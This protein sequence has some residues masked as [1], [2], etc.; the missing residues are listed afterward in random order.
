MS[1]Q[2]RW[3]TLISLLAILV[4]SA[5]GGKE[6]PT[7]TAAS[8]TAGGATTAAPE[9]T[10]TGS[11][12]P[13]NS[14][15]VS[16]EST[17][18]DD[19]LAGVPDFNTTLSQFSS[20]RWEMAFKFTGDNGVEKSGAFGIIASVEPPA[21]QMT[22]TSPDPD[23]DTGATTTMIMTQI[24]DTAYMVMSEGCINISGDSF[25]PN[26]VLSG[27]TSPEEWLSNLNDAR[28]VRP[29][30]TINE[31][32]SRHYTFDQVAFAL[33]DTNIENASGDLYVAEDGNYVTRYAFT[34]QVEAGFFSDADGPGT[35]TYE[36][37]LLDV[38]QPVTITVPEGCEAISNAYPMLDDADTVVNMTGM[39]SY[40]TSHTAEEAAEFYKEAL[41]AEGWTYDEA[42]SMQAGSFM[43]LAFTRESSQLNISLATDASSGKTTVLLQTSEE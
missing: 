28:R 21:R 34:Y 4:L 38:N 15:T 3:L 25:D 42:A 41:A 32:E 6:E 33:P 20:Y 23:P 39:V 26:E 11:V 19:S 10:R 24:G 8:T 22:V 30:E 16:A 1:K 9:A 31:V 13:T 36:F 40:S 12:A 17:T 5:C 14:P 7:P 18:T 29:N 43:S 2:L 37:N 35:V 27:F